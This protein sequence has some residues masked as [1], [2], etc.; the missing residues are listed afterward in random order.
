MMFFFGIMFGSVLTIVLAG[1]LEPT[2][3]LKKEKYN[4]QVRQ[5]SSVN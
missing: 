2:T 5:S 1:L 3:H 4:E